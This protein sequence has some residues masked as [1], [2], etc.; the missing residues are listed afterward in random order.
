MY[1]ICYIINIK[2]KIVRRHQIAKPS[3]T[4]VT[5][6]QGGGN[7]PELSTYNIHDFYYNNKL[8]PPRFNL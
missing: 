4:S 3:D 2:G 5:D 7:V 8:T 6:A 1:I